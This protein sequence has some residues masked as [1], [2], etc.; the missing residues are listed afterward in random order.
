MR[1]FLP[2]LDILMDIYSPAGQTYLNIIN[3]V[4]FQRWSLIFVVLF[5]SSGLF[6]FTYHSTQFNLEGFIMVLSASVLSGMRW[7]LA[8]IVTQKSEIG[9]EH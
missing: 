5:I 6:L 7:T 8:Q 1:F 3:Y 4:L 2:C 9:N